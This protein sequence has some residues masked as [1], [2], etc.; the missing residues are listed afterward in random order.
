MAVAA[1]SAAAVCPMCVW[2]M[3]QSSCRRNSGRT[4]C[5]TGWTVQADC[6]Y[7][8][9][10]DATRWKATGAGAEVAQLVGTQQVRVSRSWRSTCCYDAE[11]GVLITCNEQFGA[12]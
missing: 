7:N 12:T 1:K 2:P 10:E 3:W 9:T 8:H 4:S 5:L 11:L 6:T